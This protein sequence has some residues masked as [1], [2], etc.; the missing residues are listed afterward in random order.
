MIEISKALRIIKRETKPLDSE[1]VRLAESIGRI[2]AEDIF[3]DSD[4]PPFDRSQMDGYAMKAKDTRTAPVQL[5]IV[6]ESAA[7]RGWNRELKD[8]E[9]IRIMTGARVPT[10]ADSIQKI[11]LTSESNDIVSVNESTV[12][13]KYIVKKGTEIKKGKRLFRS[14]ERIDERMV[15]SLAA[16]G[17]PNVRVAIRP[18]VAILGTGTEIVPIGKK[19]GPDQIRNSNSVMLSALCEQAGATAR[20]LPQTGDDIERL[21]K[22]IASAVGLATTKSGV[23]NRQSEI[24]V[25]TGGV[26][27]G[28]YDLTKAALADLGAEIYFQQVRL[29]PGKPAVF[30]RL[31]DTLI[32]GLPGNPVSSAVTFYLF[33]RTAILLMQK[34]LR[35]DL[36]TGF[37]VMTSD[38]KAAKERDTYLPATLATDSDGRLLADPL[39]W[40]GSSDFVGFARS[41]ALVSLKRGEIIRAGQAAP[42]LYL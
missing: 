5:R 33:V 37:A 15:A 12:K 32:F 9:A 8:G 24:L 3:A 21:K 7:G 31:N 17:Y 36:R 28:K 14:G 19:P 20:E 22:V 2:L 30:A 13:G 4:M 18:K 29:R 40:H 10:G 16:F 27:V 42:I 39:N 34:S 23:R 6:G 38:A 26:S 35:T 1:E 25:I 11:E 41:D